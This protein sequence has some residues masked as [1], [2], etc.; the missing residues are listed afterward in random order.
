MLFCSSHHVKYNSE[1][2]NLNEYHMSGIDHF[3][4]CYYA[5]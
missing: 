4:V 3:E 5:K 2:E 1:N